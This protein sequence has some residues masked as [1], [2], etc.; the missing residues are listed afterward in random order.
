MSLYT[1]LRVPEDADVAT[2]QRAYMVAMAVRPR[3]VSGRLWAW[4]EGRSESGLERARRVLSDPRLRA[5]Y[6]LER[7]MNLLISDVPPRH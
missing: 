5:E 4:L 1:V 6:D 2:I 7:V 3:S